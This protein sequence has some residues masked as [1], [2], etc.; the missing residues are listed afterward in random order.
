MAGGTIIIKEG[1]NVVLRVYAREVLEDNKRV[2]IQ[3]SDGNIIEKT[4]PS[5]D[6]LML[7]SI[8][9]RIE[10]NVSDDGSNIISKSWSQDENNVESNNGVNI[11]ESINGVDSLNKGLFTVM[12]EPGDIVSKVSNYDMD[13]TFT[14]T[15][16]R[17]EKSVTIPLF[18]MQA[19]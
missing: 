14:Y 4:V 16:G 7:K 1:T 19:S 3:L 8:F 15:D 13:F 17:V 2:S 10:F 5:G 12:I 9:K 11:V 18:V 6:F